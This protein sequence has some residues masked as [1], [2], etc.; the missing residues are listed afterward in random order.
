MK[1]LSIGVLTMAAAAIMMFSA[2]EQALAATSC[3]NSGQT[4]S[5]T[6]GSCESGY[7][8]KPVTNRMFKYSISCGTS[9][10]GSCESNC[11]T[12]FGSGCKSNCGTSFGSG[13]E[14]DCSNGSC[15]SFNRLPSKNTVNVQM[16]PSKSFGCFSGNGF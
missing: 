15:S 14:S 16:M 2:P 4:Y 5:C 11:G 13:C 6:T 8:N 7:R 9:S 1:K 3:G 10:N 12:S